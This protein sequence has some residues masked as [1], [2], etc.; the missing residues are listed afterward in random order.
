MRKEEGR[1]LGR[2]HA[3][4]RDSAKWGGGD[5]HFLPRFDRGGE[6]I[7]VRMRPLR[8]N[9]RPNRLPPSLPRG[10]HGAPTSASARTD[11]QRRTRPS[12]CE[13]SPTRRVCQRVTSTESPPKLNHYGREEFTGIRGVEIGRWRKRDPKTSR[14]R[15]NRQTPVRGVG[16]EG[17]PRQGQWESPRRGRTIRTFRD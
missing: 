1:V 9:D 11:S 17:R 7:P 5:P 12:Y 15:G 2:N 14:P 6:G 3:R 10:A 13:G 16:R 4:L 8:G